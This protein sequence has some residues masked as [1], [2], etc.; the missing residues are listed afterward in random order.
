[1]TR[2]FVPTALAE[3]EEITLPARAAHH[4]RGVLRLSRDAAVE[5]FNGSGQAHAAVLTLVA[6][7]EVRVLVQ[8]P[9]DCD[10]ES[11]L[12]VTLVQGISRGERMDYTIQK[13]VEL[14]V[15][16]IVPALAQRTVV[17]LDSRRE[18]RRL[19]HWQGII[20]HAAEQS[21]RLR[22]PELAPVVPLRTWS[23]EP[24]VGER[25]ILHTRAAQPLA[26]CPRP[27][28]AVTL[29]AGPEGGFDIREVELL[30]DRGCTCVS[31]GPRIL[32]TETAA[33]CA[34]SVIQ[35]LWGDLG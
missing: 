9:I 33:L 30:Q 27:T 31:L 25:F 28:G 5:V 14:G 13:A 3:G 20:E 21:G 7:E 24:P 10:T 26:R 19:E 6:R 2:L 35:T 23:D 15:T 18:Q 17:K 1:M 32:R 16:R 34:L 8:E 11:P 4:V 22:I 29:V 12:E